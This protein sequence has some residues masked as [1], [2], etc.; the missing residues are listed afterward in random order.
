ME[1]RGINQIVI[2]LIPY[3]AAL[4]SFLIYVRAKQQF[5]HFERLCAR[6]YFSSVARISFL[7]RPAMFRRFPTKLSVFV[8]VVY[9]KYRTIFNERIF[10]CAWIKQREKYGCNVLEKITKLIFSRAVWYLFIIKIFMAHFLA[11]GD[12]NR[13]TYFNIYFGFSRSRIYILSYDRLMLYVLLF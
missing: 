6:F 10:V 13:N 12:L 5:P 2:I 9:I 8:V 1:W 11:Q 4:S 7:Q 3:Q